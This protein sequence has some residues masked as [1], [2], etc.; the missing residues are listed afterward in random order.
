MKKISVKI[1]A[2]FE[3]KPIPTQPFKYGGGMKKP[4]GKC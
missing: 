4:K 1:P 3:P 2:K